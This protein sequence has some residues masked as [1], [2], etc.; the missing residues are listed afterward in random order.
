[1]IR[2][3]GH[4][5]V[6][7]GLY[8][9]AAFVC[10]AQL[11]GMTGSETFLPRWQAMVVVFLTTSAVYALDRVKVR[12]SWMDPADL[13][14]QPER[15][16]FLQRHS[17]GVR[18]IAALELV[19]AAAVGLLLSAWAPLAVILSAGGVIAYAA[20]P[21]GGRSRIKDV[22]GL[23]NVYVAAGM[24]GFVALVCLFSFFEMPARQTPAEM[25]SRIW[26]MLIAGFILAFRIALDAAMCDIDDEPTDRQFG[27]DTWATALGR[28][29]LWKWTGLCRLVLVA[30]LLSAAPLPW[31]ARVAWSVTMI[32]GMAAL[33]L[34]R[35]SRLRDPVDLRF[36]PEAIFATVCLIAWH[37]VA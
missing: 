19:A 12:D 24:T 3:L 9:A 11:A 21:R 20:K 29:R 37:T 34:P 5:G 36:V 33:R 30:A 27:T 2:I 26:S 8:A 25:Q 7:A 15:F 6:W 16:I 32:L 22:L 31:R 4:I 28:A 17:R 14:A 35:W 23:K 13:A 10:I 1:M 18:A